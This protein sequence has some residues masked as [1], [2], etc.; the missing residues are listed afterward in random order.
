[1]LATHFSQGCVGMPPLAGTSSGSLFAF[2][3][4]SLFLSSAWKQ[5]LPH[6]EINSSPQ[7]TLDLADH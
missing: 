2:L 4:L 1:M 6:T 3:P 5:L 7:S